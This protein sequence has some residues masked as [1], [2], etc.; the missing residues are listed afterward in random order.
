MI[1]H[2]YDLAKLSKN[3]VKIEDGSLIDERGASSYA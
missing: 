1:T 2:D 3:V